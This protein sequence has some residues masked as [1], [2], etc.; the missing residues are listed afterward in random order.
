MRSALYLSRVRS[1]NLLGRIDVSKPTR[2][3]ART[4]SEVFFN[5]EY[6]QMPLT[7]L[8][9]PTVVRFEVPPCDVKLKSDAR[10]AAQVNCNLSPGTG[11]ARAK[12]FR[13]S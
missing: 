7:A 4:Y 1:S 9:V 2:H 11:S 3:Q 5:L 12:L 10:I 8:K 6:H 13:E